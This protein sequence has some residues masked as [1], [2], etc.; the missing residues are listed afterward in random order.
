MKT[1][2][3]SL[4]AAASLASMFPLFAAAP[5]HAQ[6]FPPGSYHESCRQVHW[7]GATLVAECRRRD[8]RMTGTGLPDA[9]RCGGEIANNDGHL[10]CLA[11]GAAPPRAVAPP[12]PAQGYEP[13]R[14]PGYR[15]PAAGGYDERRGRCE[16]IRGREHEM[17]ERL[18]YAPPEE[19]ERIEHRLRELHGDRERLGCER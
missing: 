18:G 17:R 6:G 8:G 16:E 2:V 3:R 4:L 13:R 12:E 10:I 11:G 7:A 14:E 19:R 15:T 5:A 1:L 9:R